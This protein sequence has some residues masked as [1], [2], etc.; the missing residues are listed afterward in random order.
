MLLEQNSRP[1]V[2][3]LQRDVVSTN[4]VRTKMAAPICIFVELRLR[5]K[6]MKLVLMVVENLLNETRG[7]IHDFLRLSLNHF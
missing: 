6:I 7:R 4:A 2:N 5:T 3:V 1:S